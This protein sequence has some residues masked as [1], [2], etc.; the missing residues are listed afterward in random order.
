M[1]WCPPEHAASLQHM[2]VRVRVR[3]MPC[4]LAASWGSVIVQYDGDAKA[5]QDGDAM[6]SKLLSS[7]L[8]RNPYGNP[9]RFPLL[10]HPHPLAVSP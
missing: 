8:G 2:R 6:L 7:V 5:W 3:A 4:A 1:P 10:S 9:H